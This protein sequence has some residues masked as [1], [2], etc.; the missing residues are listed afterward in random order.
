ME[1]RPVFIASDVHLGATSPEQESAFLDWVSTVPDQASHLILNGDL[2]DFWFE[3]PRGIPAGHERALA[4]LKETVE[5][6]LPITLMGGNHDWW[7]GRYLEEEIG[8]EFLRDPVVRD[9]NGFRSF[10]AHGDGLDT[11]DLGYQALRVVL[12]SRLTRWAFGQLGP[13]VGSRVAARVSRTEDRWI[14][15][16]AETRR[17]SLH[18]ESWAAR[19]LAD[20]PTL[21]LV[22]L[23]HTH[24]PVLR[25]VEP[26]RWYVNSGDWVFHR[27]YVSVSAG[28]GPRLLRAGP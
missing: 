24:L 23:G 16:D 28:E 25:E 13:A 8:L 9:L 10:L 15:P 5:A 17:K 2:F 7:G 6:G 27:S 20:D 1:P 19:A 21:D 11:S 22:L 18:L 12:R 3:F 14:E 4:V 26:G